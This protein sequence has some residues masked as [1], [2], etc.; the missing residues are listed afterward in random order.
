MTNPPDK[1]RNDP[2][3]DPPNDPWADRPDQ[4]K[5]IRYVPER[6]AMQNLADAFSEDIL[7][8]PAEHLLA[9]V[10]E[11]HGRADILARDFD[12]ITA[13]AEQRY[14]Q[15][16]RQARL[17]AIFVTPFAFIARRPVMAGAA[18]VA[19]LIAGSASV[20]QMGRYDYGSAISPLP[21]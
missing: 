6:E 20:L 5:T 11:D 7:H 21:P 10:A 2:P 9:E 19:V 4:E 8:A 3:N 12:R 16:R 15:V 17:R 14:R 18:A 1:P 13:Q